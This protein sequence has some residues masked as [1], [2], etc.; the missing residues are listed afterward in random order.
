MAKLQN[1]QNLL[2]NCEE[3]LKHFVSA[4]GQNKAQ[5]S[6]Q[7]ALLQKAIEKAFNQIKIDISHCNEDILKKYHII[8]GQANNH[9]KEKGKEEEES[10]LKN[11]HGNFLYVA[12][13]VS[14]ANQILDKGRFY[15][16]CSMKFNQRLLEKIDRTSALIFD[17]NM[18]MSHNKDLIPVFNRLVKELK[19]N[20]FTNLIMRIFNQTL[21]QI[22]QVKIKMLDERIKLINKCIT[23]NLQPF[24]GMKYDQ[25]LF[26]ND[27]LYE[28]MKYYNQKFKNPEQPTF[29]YVDKGD[30]DHFIGRQNMS[31]LDLIWEKILCKNLTQDSF[32]KQLEQ[33]YDRALHGKEIY[34]EIRDP[35][36]DG[37]YRRIKIENK[38]QF[39]SLAMTEYF[40]SN[41]FKNVKI[42]KVHKDLSIETFLKRKIFK[43]YINLKP[44]SNYFISSGDLE[45]DKQAL[46]QLY[47]KYED[48]FGQITVPAGKNKKPLVVQKCGQNNTSEKYITYDLENLSRED[49]INLFVAIEKK[50]NTGTECSKDEYIK[51]LKKVYKKHKDKTVCIRD[52]SKPF[53]NISLKGISLQEFIDLAIPKDEDQDDYSNI[54]IAIKVG[55]KLHQNYLKIDLGVE[56]G[57]L[58]EDDFTYNQDGII[59]NITSET[60]LRPHAR[61]LKPQEDFTVEFYVKHQGTIP[62]LFE[63][64]H[65]AICARTPSGEEYSLGFYPEYGFGEGAYNL[66]GGFL[67]PLDDEIYKPTHNKTYRKVTYKL[68]D[69]QA[70]VKFIKW[71]EK[72]KEITPNYHPLYQNC[73]H[74][75]NEASHFIVKNCGAKKIKRMTSNPLLI[76]R[77]KITQLFLRITLYLSQ[78]TPS[79]RKYA[80]IKDA[81]IVH[82]TETNEEFALNIENILGREALIPYLPADFIVAH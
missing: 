12:K 72:I 77:Q 13:D 51:I 50:V 40:K 20:W 76:L 24:L 19:G 52:P 4:K 27:H 74:F 30:L 3:Q 60:M 5:L 34:L 69:Y 57:P 33:L 32:I 26:Q 81:Y 21:F 56:S 29:N 28:R 64:G 42:I 58:M 1:I 16:K 46:V 59:K 38:K 6:N 17:E 43:E 8:W 68:P 55:E 61:E 31:E 39:I 73:A 36:K 9:L 25:L 35:D 14:E 10:S 66:Q 49:F 80:N 71:V 48:S 53:E 11:V 63:A 54:E 15:H 78:M 75:A 22:I 44:I 7:T 18:R 41:N 82:L 79:L 70:F 62:T 47:D 23:I 2:N 67:N 65:V 45:K 37:M